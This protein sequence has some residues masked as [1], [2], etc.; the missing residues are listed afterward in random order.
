MIDGLRATE[1][2]QIDRVVH[3]VRDVLGD[4][5]LGVY[6]FGSAVSSSGLR[7]DSDLDI[8]VVASR[9]TTSA[10]RRRLIDELLGI[11]RSRDD[12][13]EKRHLEVTI[14]SE[15]DVRPWRY[16]PPMDFQ[17]GDWW[18]TE[19]ASGERAPWKSP[20]ADLAIVL[21]SARAD[22]VALFGP[23]IKGLLDVVPVADLR[24]ASIEV[25]PELLANLDDD[26]RNVLLTLARIWFTVETGTL[27][28][29][30][31]AAAWAISRLPDG[32][33]DALRRARDGYIG[34]ARDVWDADAIASARGDAAAIREVIVAV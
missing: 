14:V 6:L 5:V 19:F 29:K 3:L 7:D 8:L 21:T 28:S 18:R 4:A 12:T 30:D 32:R 23:P 11:S 15:P 16:P 34:Q 10:E 20:N 1:R 13:I 9:P 26:V 25:I 33:G 31:S 17:Y 22:G 24:R 2:G 27:T